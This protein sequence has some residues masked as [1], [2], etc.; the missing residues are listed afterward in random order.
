MIDGEL[1][2]LIVGTCSVQQ[3]VKR[4]ENL[5]ELCRSCSGNILTHI[6]DTHKKKIFN[7]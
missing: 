3:F 4:D 5:N 2:E 7:T 1:E 6:V